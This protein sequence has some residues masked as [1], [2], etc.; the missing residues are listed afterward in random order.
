[1]TAVPK[2]PRPLGAKVGELQK[3]KIMRKHTEWRELVIFRK[4]LFHNNYDKFQMRSL[5]FFN[6]PTVDLA[7]DTN[8]Y[9]ESCDG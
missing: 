9:P 1:M 4:L 7:A 3:K 5:D 2:E 6:S 8:E